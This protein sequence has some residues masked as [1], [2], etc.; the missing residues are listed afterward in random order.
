MAITNVYILAPSF[1][2]LFL[3]NEPHLSGDGRTLEAWTKAEI[4]GQDILAM[5]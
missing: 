4:G 2:V 5:M 3:Y 1:F